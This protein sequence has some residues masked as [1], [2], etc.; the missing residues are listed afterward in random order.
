MVVVVV[1]WQQF[2]LMCPGAI[3]ARGYAVVLSAVRHNNTCM[4]YHRDSSSLRVTDCLVRTLC[5]FYAL[6]KLKSALKVFHSRIVE[7]VRI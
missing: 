5:S 7:S 4:F 1:W 6:L 2:T 3:R